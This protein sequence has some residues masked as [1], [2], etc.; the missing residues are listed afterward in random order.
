MGQLQLEHLF[1]SEVRRLV[2]HV[3][4]TTI[5]GVVVN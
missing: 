5:I 1:F 4:L 3:D 2:I